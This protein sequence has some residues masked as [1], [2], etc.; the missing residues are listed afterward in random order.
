MSL[1]YIEYSKSG[2]LNFQDYN[3]IIQFHGRTFDSKAD[4]E[5][6]KSKLASLWEGKYGRYIRIDRD[7]TVWM[8]TQYSDGLQTAQYLDQAHAEHS[9][10]FQLRQS[11]QMI[12][13]QFINKLGS[14]GGVVFT[15]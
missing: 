4:L 12:K 9:C 6:L 7:L 10:R 5:N 11:N 2:G 13:E 1:V 14:T 3:F 8:V 15:S